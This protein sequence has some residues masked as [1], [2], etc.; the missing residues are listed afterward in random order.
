MITFS[1]ISLL[2][3]SQGLRPWTGTR[4]KAY[5]KLTDFNL[6]RGGVEMMLNKIL[7]SACRALL[8]TSNIQSFDLYSIPM[9]YTYPYDYTLH[10]T[11]EGN[12]TQSNSPKQPRSEISRPKF[13][14]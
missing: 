9:K 8:G 13:R 5:P 2:Y 3:S 12:E 7:Q 10:T 6:E 1:Y 4:M 14:F 11:E